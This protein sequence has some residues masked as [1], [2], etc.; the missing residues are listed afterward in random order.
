MRRKR[1]FRVLLQQAHWKQ[2]RKCIFERHRKIWVFDDIMVMQ[3]HAHCSA[4]GAEHVLQHILHAFQTEYKWDILLEPLMEQ[5]RRNPDLM[6]RARDKL[7]QTFLYA[8]IAGA[9]FRWLE[10]RCH[11][12]VMA[13]ADIMVCAETRRLWKCY[14]QC[15]TERNAL[16]WLPDVD[17]V[18]ALI[19]L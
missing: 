13:Q 15:A 12:S 16:N 14:I 1:T 2:L 19:C 11:V 7:V 10:N 3:R 4:H 6:L 17:D 18:S 8:G 5:L 9:D